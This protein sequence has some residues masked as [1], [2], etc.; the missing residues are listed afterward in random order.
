L[1]GLPAAFILR[2]VDDI[3]IFAMRSVKGR[4]LGLVL[5]V[6]IGV[7]S[8]MALVSADA[9]D[10][11]FGI[12][13]PSMFNGIV[14]GAQWIFEKNPW[15]LA[16]VF[17][18]I[19]YAFI[20]YYY[21]L[22]RSEKL[23]QKVS[24]EEHMS[25]TMQNS[26]SMWIVTRRLREK[27][28]W[29]RVMA[30][31]RVNIS[32]AVMCCWS[33]FTYFNVPRKAEKA[34]VVSL[35][36]NMNVPNGYQG[37]SGGFAEK[38]I[39]A[40]LTHTET[41]PTEIVDMCVHYHPRQRRV[42][43]WLTRYMRSGLFGVED[44]SEFCPE[45]GDE[46]DLK[47]ENGSMSLPQQVHKNVL[48]AGDSELLTAHDRFRLMTLTDNFDDII[49]RFPLFV[50]HLDYRDAELLQVQRMIRPA[51]LRQFMEGAL[52]WFT[53]NGRAFRDFE[54]KDVTKE[55]EE[56]LQSNMQQVDGVDAVYYDDFQAW[57]L[58]LKVFL[59]TATLV[60]TLREEEL[61]RLSSLEALRL[62][63]IFRPSDGMIEELY[64]SITRSKPT[65][66]GAGTDTHGAGDRMPVDSFGVTLMEPASDMWTTLND[67]AVS[68]GTLPPH[69]AANIHEADADYI[70]DL[71]SDGK[72][73]IDGSVTGDHD[74]EDTDIG[75]EVMS[76]TVSLNEA[77]LPV[78]EPT[79]NWNL[80]IDLSPRFDEMVSFL[81]SPMQ[82]ASGWIGNSEHKT[83]PADVDAG[84]GKADFA[85]GNEHDTSDPERGLDRR[86]MSLDDSIV[87][88]DE[89]VESLSNDVFSEVSGNNDG[90]KPNLIL[91]G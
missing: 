91:R 41:V 65:T 83:T 58:D 20:H 69:D 55:F 75:K 85:E 64:S 8:I 87:S 84:D 28:G 70:G 29:N 60:A 44:D 33:P 61:L 86:L 32:K 26:G 12:V 5:G 47:E 72:N 82:L 4:K 36:R 59:T 71:S 14:L 81:G 7:P 35:W 46:E 63:E 2:Q 56:W 31:L 10:T 27:H 19:I 79:S 77:S 21:I 68:L 37:R 13:V 18:G 17:I 48:R 50:I 40:N 78:P 23:L 49:R 45:F 74:A 80:N 66:D 38:V 11:F 67:I 51:C 54:K 16:V 62:S 52:C 90:G 42:D 39:I 53:P 9:T 25:R 88:L 22:K 34:R 1:K 3:D 57:L 76:N 30:S 24:R 73:S 43:R 15:I 89:S 6:L